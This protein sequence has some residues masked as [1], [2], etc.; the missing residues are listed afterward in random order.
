[1]LDQSSRG[2]QAT[3]VQETKSNDKLSSF[4]FCKIR[5]IRSTNLS[6]SV[7]LHAHDV[8]FKGMTP[9]IPKT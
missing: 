2:I 8:R 5:S 7:V 4:K 1:M 6:Q 9:L 3:D